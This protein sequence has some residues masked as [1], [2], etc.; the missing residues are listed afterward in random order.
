M[1]HHAWQSKG[2]ENPRGY[3]EVSRGA[4]TTVKEEL[5]LI[6]L[7]ITIRCG[8]VKKRKT[9]D[10]IQNLI[11]W[12]HYWVKIYQ[13]ICMQ[14]LMVAL[15]F[16]WM[17]T[18]SVNHSTMHDSGHNAVVELIHFQ[19]D[20]LKE[21]IMFNNIVKEHISRSELVGWKDQVSVYTPL[22]RQCSSET[23]PD[24]PWWHSPGPC[25]RW[26]CLGSLRLGKVKWVG[27]S[28]SVLHRCRPRGPPHRGSAAE[29]G[30]Y[31]EGHEC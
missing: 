22:A 13:Y 10:I 7:S 17:H 29:P 1:K 3:W 27:G 4:P 6:L 14:G 25:L 30:M 31:T 2:L 24:E 16:I 26:C 20:A 28:L 5:H 12:Q 19:S 9:K 15:N 23:A 8:P 18:L 21:R 11:R